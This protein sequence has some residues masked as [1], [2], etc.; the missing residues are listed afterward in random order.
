MASNYRDILTQ[1][2]RKPS[3]REELLR[4]AMKLVTL[5]MMDDEPE[6]AAPKMDGTGPEIY[7][8]PRYSPSP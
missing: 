6:G 5:S 8:A 1:V 7:V 2:E 4:L 3:R